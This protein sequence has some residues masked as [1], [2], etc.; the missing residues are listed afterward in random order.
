L[1]V[2]EAGTLVR[3]GLV[4]TLSVGVL[5]T[6]LPRLLRPRISLLRRLLLHRTMKLLLDLSPTL[7]LVIEDHVAE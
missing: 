2:V 1:A 3:L 5:A 6:P 7:R 4:T